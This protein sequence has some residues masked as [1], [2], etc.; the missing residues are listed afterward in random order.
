MPV[1]AERELA[2]QQS[3]T[4]LVSRG[5]CLDGARHEVCGHCTKMF[6]RSVLQ[7]RRRAHLIH[8]I[9]RD[10]THLFLSRPFRAPGRLQEPRRRR[11]IPVDVEERLGGEDPRKAGGPPEAQEGA[12]PQVCGGGEYIAFRQVARAGA[13]KQQL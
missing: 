2:A 1:A 4:A 12:W 5:P 13:G 6:M 3:L 7:D 8:R 11:A 10:I 9:I